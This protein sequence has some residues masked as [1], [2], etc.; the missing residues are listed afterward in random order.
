MEEVANTHDSEPTP[1]VQHMELP[2]EWYGDVED[3]VARTVRRW[4]MIQLP[5]TPAIVCVPAI[6]I[7]VNYEYDDK[8]WKFKS[9]RQ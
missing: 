2:E 5:R 9:L 8:G 6:E 4:A 7:P 3:V 1:Q